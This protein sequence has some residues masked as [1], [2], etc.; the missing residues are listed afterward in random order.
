MKQK[1]KKT[2][3]VSWMSSAQLDANNKNRFLKS[4]KSFTE[5]LIETKTFKHFRLDGHV[6]KVDV[7]HTVF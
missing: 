5:I 1:K 3:N 6:A 7:R 4:R 2:S